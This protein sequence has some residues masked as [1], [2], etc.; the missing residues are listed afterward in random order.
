MVVFIIIIVAKVDYRIL[1]LERAIIRD[2]NENWQRSRLAMV[3][4][5]R[6]ILTHISFN[7]LLHVLHVL[8]LYFY[9]DINN[10]CFIS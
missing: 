3:H 1:E 7:M 8:T 2:N 6:Q 10:I 5:T 4:L 9:E